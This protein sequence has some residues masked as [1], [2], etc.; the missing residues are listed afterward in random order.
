MLSLIC[1]FHCITT[2]RIC[3]LFENF[4]NLSYWSFSLTYKLWTETKVCILH[5]QVRFKSFPCWAIYFKKIQFYLLK[6]FVVDEIK[7]L[8]K[9]QVS[10]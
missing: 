9:K 4:W 2:T 1:I 6:S 3:A 8:G 10:G 5:M 7:I